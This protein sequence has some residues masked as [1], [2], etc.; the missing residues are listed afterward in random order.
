[1]S[2]GIGAFGGTSQCY[3]FWLGFTQCRLAAPNPTLCLLEQADYMECLTRDKLKR[4]IASKLVEAKRLA[5]EAAHPP[6]AGAQ[7]GGGH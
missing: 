1:M 3:R 4:R 5:D 6:A 2:S 7:H